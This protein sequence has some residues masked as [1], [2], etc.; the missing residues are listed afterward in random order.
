MTAT[1]TYTRDTGAFSI[2]K[3]VEGG[4]PDFAKGS[5]TFAY[6]CTGGIEG[7]LTVPG[8]GTAV[9]SPRIPAGATCTLTED[10]ASAAREGYAVA[11]TLSQDNAA[12]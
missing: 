9:T 4:A 11:S 8:D 3:T 10:A 7:E 12:P 2:A 5:F 1:N 6:S